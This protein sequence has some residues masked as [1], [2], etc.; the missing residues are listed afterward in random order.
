MGVSW[1]DSDKPTA[2]KLRGRGY[3]ADS[4]KATRADAGRLVIFGNYQ[5]GRSSGVR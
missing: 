1:P 4:G 3:R 2:L 5:F